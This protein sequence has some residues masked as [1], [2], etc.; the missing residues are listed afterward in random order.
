MIFFL[1]FTSVIAAEETVNMATAESGA[2]WSEYSKHYGYMIHIATEAFRLS[3]IQTK[4]TFYPWKRSYATAKSNRADCTCCWFFADERTKDFHYSDPVFVEAMV[5]FHL[6]S[7]KFD[8]NTVDDLREVKVGGNI[9]FHYGDD[10]QNAE[11]EGIIHVDRTVT[12]IQNFKKLLAGRIQIFPLAVSTGYETLRQIYP[13]ETVKL[14]TYHP[15]QILHKN[16]YLLIPV[17][18]EKNKAERLLTSFNQGLKRLRETGKYDKIVKDIE[19]GFYSPM[20]EKWIR[21]QNDK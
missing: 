10:F 14:F 9:A 8:W 18:M 7:F 6:K 3:G 2:G 4:I 12:S 21:Q 11:K 1:Y 19:K 5:F 20:K 17:R 16:L 13:P 15:K